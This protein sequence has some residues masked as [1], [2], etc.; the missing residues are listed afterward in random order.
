VRSEGDKAKQGTQCVGDKSFSM[1][2]NGLR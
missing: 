1:G 2:V